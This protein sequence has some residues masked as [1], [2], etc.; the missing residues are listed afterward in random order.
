MNSL[1]TL[2]R[3]LF[4]KLDAFTSK[5]SN[6]E[7]P[8]VLIPHDIAILWTEGLEKQQHP[9]TDIAE[10]LFDTEQ[11]IEIVEST[12]EDIYKEFGDTID[13]SIIVV[14][15]CAILEKVVQQGDYD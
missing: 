5:Q 9:D 13:T 10:Y 8:K 2:H 12:L 7:L 1:I 14:G 4:L 3:S 6:V 15:I 11:S